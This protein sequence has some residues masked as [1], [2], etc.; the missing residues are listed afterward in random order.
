MKLLRSTEGC[1]MTDWLPV[2][3]FLTFR[4]YYLFLIASVDIEDLRLY[5]LTEASTMLPAR[6]C[7]FCA[8]LSFLFA[9]VCHSM[10]CHPGLTA[11]VAIRLA[12]FSTKHLWLWPFLDLTS[13]SFT[14]ERGIYWLALFVCLGRFRRCRTDTWVAPEGTEKSLTAALLAAILL[15]FVPVPIN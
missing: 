5:Y 8:C 2:Q 11:P 13:V 1:C 14:T 12:A 15:V 3:T 10:A 9:C 7:M 4:N 6:F